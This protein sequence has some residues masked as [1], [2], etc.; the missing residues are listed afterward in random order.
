MICEETKVAE[1]LNDVWQV[2]SRPPINAK[3]R[4][5]LHTRAANRPFQHN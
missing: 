3:Q 2:D 4:S 5:A 1:K